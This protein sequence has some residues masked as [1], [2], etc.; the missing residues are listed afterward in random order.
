M[1]NR[2]ANLELLR[3]ISMLMIVVLHLLGKTSLL[4][5]ELPINSFSYGF[6]WFLYA[7][8]MTSV[9]CYIIISGYFLI[10]A[11]WKLKKALNIYAQ[12]LFYSVILYIVAKYI[13]QIELMSGFSRVILPLT[14]REYWFATVYLGLYCLFPYINIFVNSLSKSQLQRFIFVVALFFSVIPTIFCSKEWLGENGA[15]GIGWFVFLYTIGAY[16]KKYDVE[17]SMAKKWR[18]YW[19]CILILPLSKLVVMLSDK[20]I[21]LIP[22]EYMIEK[23]EIL[24]EFHTIPVL[25]ASIF[26]FLCFRDMQIQSVVASNI[27]NWFGGATFGVYLIHNNRNI[28]HYLWDSLGVIEKV[29]NGKVWYIFVC[30]V[31]VFVV[32]STIEN[33]RKQLWNCIGINRLIN[34]IG[35][36]MQSKIL[37]NRD[38]E[39]SEMN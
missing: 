14:R 38:I 35:D 9:N 27:I 5:K 33:M 1:K 22:M 11:K 30:G 8:C 31:G 21:N 17:I 3:V 16:V 6:C 4:W 15:Y 28:A 10:N 23:S 7:L 2:L 12:V 20:F 13:L 18:N 39:K 24:F 26:C 34:G 37:L 36:K 19:I 32:C 25:A 29:K